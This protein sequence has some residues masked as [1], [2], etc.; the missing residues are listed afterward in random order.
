MCLCVW[1]TFLKFKI[2]CFGAVLIIK[3]LL[4]ARNLQLAAKKAEAEKLNSRRTFLIGNALE[5]SFD[6]KK[7]F[8]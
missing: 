7:L 6:F 1:V 4:M 2:N 5:K 3:K 8:S